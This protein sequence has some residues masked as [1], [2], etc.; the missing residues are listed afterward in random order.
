MRVLFF[1]NLR[2]LAGIAE[3]TVPADIEITTVQ[4]L[5]DYVANGNPDLHVALCA[6]TTKAAI[7]T[8]FAEFSSALNGADEVAFMPPFSGG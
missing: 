2:E 6:K 3:T 8:K 5:A 1:G 4:E 7:N